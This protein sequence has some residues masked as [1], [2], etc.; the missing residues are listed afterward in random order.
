M[1]IDV[2]GS[3]RKFAACMNLMILEVN[4][5]LD[6]PCVL[7]L[8]WNLGAVIGVVGV[9]IQSTFSKARLK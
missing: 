8:G 7:A 5:T 4:E 9:T 1:G 2:A 6:S 3:P